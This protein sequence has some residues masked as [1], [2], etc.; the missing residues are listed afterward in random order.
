MIHS[1]AIIVDAVI[2]CHP[3]ALG[4]RVRSLLVT[5]LDGPAGR[6]ESK[7]GNSYS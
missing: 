1:T 6:V 3:S 5:C 7:C 2:L 4:A